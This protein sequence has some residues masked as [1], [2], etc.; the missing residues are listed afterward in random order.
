MAG[1]TLSAANEAK[2]RSAL[3]AIGAV[4]SVLAEDAPAESAAA[5]SAAEPDAE[6][7][8]EAAL[9][10]EIVPLAEARLVELTEYSP[11]TSQA[12]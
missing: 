9:E 10:G 3:E 6:T 2:L 1:R 12:G 8:I 5:E 4:L 11:L 7:V